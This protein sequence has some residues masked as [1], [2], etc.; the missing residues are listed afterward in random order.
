MVVGEKLERLK[1]REENWKMLKGEEYEI[2]MEE[3][4]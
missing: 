3:D 2:E 1:E 4:T